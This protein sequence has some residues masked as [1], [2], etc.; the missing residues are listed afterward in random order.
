QNDNGNIEPERLFVLEAAGGEALEVVFQEEYFQKIGVAVLHGDKPGEHHG[1]IQDHSRPPDGTAQDRPLA[2]QRGEGK[3]D[4]NR[5]KGRHRTLGEGCGSYKEIQIEKPEFAVR[6][7]PGVPAQHADAERGGKLHV[8]R[9]STR[10]N[11]SH[12]TISY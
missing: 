2:S 10:L 4:D 3:D 9:K 12:I 6:L 7:I 1:E 11:S 8:D 5:Q